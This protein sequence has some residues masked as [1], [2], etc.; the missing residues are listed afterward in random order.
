[1]SAPGHQSPGLDLDCTALIYLHYTILYCNELNYTVLQWTKLYSTIFCRQKNF[2]LSNLEEFTW[3]LY[4]LWVS[5]IF[6]CLIVCL[7]V[8]KVKPVLIYQMNNI[9]Q[10]HLEGPN[11]WTYFKMP[12]WPYFINLNNRGGHKEKQTRTPKVGLNSSKF[13]CGWFLAC[14]S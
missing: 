12:C 1:M 5:H 8:A 10:N 11:H 14:K 6:L 13:I 3:T 4:I 2:V 7:N 9:F